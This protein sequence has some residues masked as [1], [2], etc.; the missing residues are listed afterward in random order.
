MMYWYDRFCDILSSVWCS[1][2]LVPPNSLEISYG[3]MRC[4]TKLQLQGLSRGIT[5]EQSYGYVR[6]DTIRAGLGNRLRAVV[7]G[8]WRVDP[9][10]P[11]HLSPCIRLPLSG[12]T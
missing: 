11:L 2:E 12:P 1:I 7:T 8:L 4:V 3:Y 10:D 6:V 5:Y 9:H